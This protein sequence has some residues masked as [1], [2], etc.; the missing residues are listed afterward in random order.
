[1][2]NY[3]VK[4]L[5]RANQLKGRLYG[6]LVK[7]MYQEYKTA[8]DANKVLFF[9]GE[10]MVGTLY[11][12]EQVLN[13]FLSAH[14]DIIWN[15]WGLAL[16]VV[17][18]NYTVLDNSIARHTEAAWLIGCCGAKW[19]YTLN[20]SMYLDVGLY[21]GDMPVS[22][23]AQVHKGKN[24]YVNFNLFDL[25]IEWKEI[26]PYS[27]NHIRHLNPALIR[28]AKSRGR[29]IKNAKAYLRKKYDWE[30]GYGYKCSGSKE[31]REFI[32]N[33]AN[34]TN[35]TAFSQIRIHRNK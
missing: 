23:I 35:H 13:I 3:L 33:F 8:S 17:A 5:S 14:K 20:N 31:T 32:D 22:G 30:Y 6:Y 12:K 29:K 26:D 34:K 9:K 19:Q 11:R 4:R 16:F 1:M 27:H 15:H 25:K 10:K 21:W 24:D 28:P 18:K 2:V 7:K